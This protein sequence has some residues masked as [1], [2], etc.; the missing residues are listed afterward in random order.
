MIYV[1]YFF[2]AVLIFFS[3][4]SLK[5]GVDYLRFFRAE[6]GRAAPDD[7]RRVTVFAPHRG[8]EDGLGSN[9]SALLGQDH[10]NYEVIFVT[11]PD[12][13]DSDLVARSAAAGARV[14][15]KFITAPKAEHS[16]QK[17]EN[18]REAVI[19]ADAD[20][21]VFVF[22]DS[23]VR[24]ASDWLRYLAAPTSE[25]GI[26][27]ATGY[28]WFLSDRPSPGTELRSAWN[29]SIASALGPDTGANFCWG[30]SMAISREIFD[31]L[32][33]LGAWKGALSDDFVV[34]REMNAA[35]LPIVFVPQAM[36]A[37]L[38]P[39]TVGEMLEFTTRQMKITRVYA[40]QL[41]LLSFF[42]SALFCGVMAAAIVLMAASSGV[43]FIVSLITLISV[44]AC[45]VGKSTLRLAAIR[46]AMPQ[47]DQELRRQVVIQAVL[48]AA[49]PPIYL[50][51]CLAALFSHKVQWRGI[52]YLLKSARETVIIRD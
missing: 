42:G 8:A 32:D 50:Y 16:S 30:G 44:G 18:L 15:V 26:G 39:C 21:E 27:A 14:P 9:F 7:R 11:D 20:S 12:S 6:L 43:A 1:F 25:P 35:G 28:R 10:V 48:F 4:R 49:T 41:W 17:I 38:G 52:K 5:G 51:N 3:I 45:S 24:P 36:S 19:H 29:A 37:S 46:S 23:D 40:P 13:G 47:F 22:V 2:A 34:T 31:R 33:I